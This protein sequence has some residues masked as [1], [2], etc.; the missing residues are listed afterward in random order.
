MRQ[1]S[2]PTQNAFSPTGFFEKW[3]TFP[4]VLVGE[5]SLVPRGKHIVRVVVVPEEDGPDM[6]WE[7]EFDF[8][9]YDNKRAVDVDLFRNSH[10]FSD[11]EKGAKKKDPF[12]EMESDPFEEME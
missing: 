6:N 7:Y 9:M 5:I 12:E 4:P 11:G 8:T 2:T 1:E 10:N 3:W